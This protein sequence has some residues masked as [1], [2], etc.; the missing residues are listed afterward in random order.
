MPTQALGGSASLKQMKRN[1]SKQQQLNT[2]NNRYEHEKRS[3]SRH[4]IHEK[5]STERNFL[6]I[7]WLA[8]S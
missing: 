5:I 6:E 8:W 4:T 3:N 1:L 2:C 7:E